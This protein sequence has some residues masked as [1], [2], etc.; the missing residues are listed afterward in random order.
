MTEL[1][2]AMLLLSNRSF[3]CIPF[4]PF[5]LSFAS[6]G[7]RGVDPT[8]FLPGVGGFS[9]IARI[10]LEQSG[11]LV[12]S[13]YTPTSLLYALGPT[14]PWEKQGGQVAWRLNIRWLMILL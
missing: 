14:S 11:A 12:V 13:H 1:S 5:L 3:P 4:L 2:S 7:W 10:K 6:P 8:Y 9:P